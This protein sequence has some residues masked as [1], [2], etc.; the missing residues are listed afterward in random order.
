MVSD[1][2]QLRAVVFD[3]DGLMLDTES[4]YRLA[5][6]RAGADLGYRIDDR[7]YASMLGLSGPDTE[8]ELV[9]ALG[10]DF[11]VGQFWIRC[12]E[13]WHQHVAEQGIPRKPGLTEL[14]RLLEELSIPKAVASSGG[15]Q[16]VRF[17][18]RAAGLD[19]GFS[20]IVTAD[21]VAESKPAPDVYLATAEKLGLH[22]G[23]CLALEDSDVGVISATTAG[24]LTIMIPDLRQPSPRVASL[25][26][27]VVPSLAEATPI[28]LE[29]LSPVSMGETGR[30]QSA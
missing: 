19:D 29:L 25:A 23:Q 8:V 27:R 17:S 24:M 18:L 22:P 30:R 3:M 21:Q 15:E 26:Y 10:T 11:P 20:C 6:W 16:S 2:K 7:L 28:V 14:L 12:M 9:R 5:F 1:S 4:I 13:H